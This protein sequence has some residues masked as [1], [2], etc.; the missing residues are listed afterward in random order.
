MGSKLERARKAQ[1]AILEEMKKVAKNSGKSIAQVAPWTPF[2]PAE[3]IPELPNDVI[4]INS[5]YQ[6]NMRRGVAPSPFGKYIELSIKTRDKMAFHDWRDFQRIKNELV[7]PEYEGIEL[8]PSESRLVDTANQ[9]FM[10]VFKPQF[11]GN[12][13][14]F[15]FTTRLL[16]S[17]GTMG[18]SQR[19]FEVE[20]SDAMNAEQFKKFIEDAIERKGEQ[21][22]AEQAIPN[23][24]PEA[25]A[26]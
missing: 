8:Y 14:P 18:S 24:A 15:G 10:F 11:P 25:V 21:S 9:F 3:K 12:H 6:V 16:A 2:V 17:E 20:P 1:Q 26:K 23:R 22:D 5:R 19:P 7:G 13:F 4:Y